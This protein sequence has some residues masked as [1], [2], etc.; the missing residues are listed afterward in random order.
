MK[1][2]EL[3]NKLKK[4]NE[5]KIELPKGNKKRNKNNQDFNFFQ[6]YIGKEQKEKFRNTYIAIVIGILVFG[7]VI[8][9]AWN[10]MKIKETQNEIYRIKK[11]VDSPETKKK[12]AE[13]DNLKKKQ[14][15]L[16]KYYNGVYSINNSV[17]KRSIISSELMRQICSVIPQKVSFKSISIDGGSIQISGTAESR[18]SIAELQ[19]NLKLLDF[20]DEVQIPNISGNSQSNGKQEANSSTYSFSLKCTLKDVGKK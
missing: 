12:L 4:L 1:V 17:E 3:I 18:T 9:F 15:I 14:E 7:F 16:N 11:I 6:P 8:S 5:I 19:Y 20:V 13:I 2:D 10:S